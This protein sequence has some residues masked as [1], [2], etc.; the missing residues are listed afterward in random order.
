MTNSIDDFSDILS[1]DE[2][3]SQHTWL[4]LGGNAERFYNPTS[5][6][7]LIALVRC[8][9]AQDIP[10]RIL[11]G[12]SNLLV[13]DRGVSGA[14]IRVIDPLLSSVTIDGSIV[15]AEGGATLSH[16]VT[17]SVRANL[18]GLENLVGIPGTIGGAIVGNAGLSSR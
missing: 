8:C 16:V 6:D 13:D 1:R 3:L 2:P 14:V 5:R 17:E 9:I 12:G 4:K 15:K 11:G 18:A 10:V 7:Q